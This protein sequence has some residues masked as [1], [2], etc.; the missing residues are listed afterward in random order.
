MN[1]G[2]HKSD[3][4]TS[5]AEETQQ[6]TKESNATSMLKELHVQEQ[7]KSEAMK[8]G[9]VESGYGA[10]TRNL[11]TQIMQI[12]KAIEVKELEEQLKELT[13]RKKLLEQAS[14]AQVKHEHEPH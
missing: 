2:F 5:V 13:A 10:S 11:T 6:H 9:I 1:A 7:T 8:A 3:G 12:K 14:E 4:S